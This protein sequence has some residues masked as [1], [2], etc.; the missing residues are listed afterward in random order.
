MNALIFKYSGRIGHF[1]RAEANVSAPT[2][3]VPPRTVLLGLIGAILG[4]SKDEPQ[5]TL[6]EAQIALAGKIPRTH[7]HTVKLRKDPPAALPLIIKAS[8]MTY[9]NT[10]PEKPA[11]ICQEW[12]WQP[13]FIVYIALPEPY[14]DDLHRRLKER[15]WHFNPC[16]GL[17]EMMADVEL[18]DNS[19]CEASSL[20][21]GKYEI[22][23]VVPQSAGQLD[24]DRV[25]TNGLTLQTLRMPRTVTND[26]VF[27]HASYYVERDGRP[28]PFET[29]SAWR[30]GD[31]TVIF[32]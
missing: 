7:W 6:N 29:D 22:S 25:F 30:I 8:S 20:P 27:T 1:L 18:L 23:T 26:R 31:R 17:S 12:L 14:H 2:Y 9:K 32:L 10:V 24:T 4:L 5:V 11:L 15:C 16:M 19:D 28:I 3:P 13:N 21:F